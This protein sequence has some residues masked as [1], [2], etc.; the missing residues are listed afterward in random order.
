[1]NLTITKTGANRQAK[2]EYTC[3]KTTDEAV[4]LIHDPAYKSRILAGGT[5]LFVAMRGEPVD[6]GRLVDISQIPELKQIQKDEDIVRIGAAVTFA[7]ILESD[8]LRQETPFLLEAARTIGSPQ[9]RNLA[10]MGGNVANAAACADSLPVL[11]C[12]EASASL[13]GGRTRRDV[14]IEQLILGPNRTQIQPDELLI[15][16]SF[17]IL[18][19]GTRTAFV[20]LG[21]RN[22]LATTRLSLAA[23]GYANEDR[24]IE[25]LR[26]A[27]GSVTP[28]PCRLKKM[29]EE[30][31][32][33]VVTV[34]FLEDCSQQ[35]AKS[36]TEITGKRW[37]TEYKEK[38]MASMA[39][40]VLTELFF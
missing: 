37:S 15:Q 22:A 33:Q 40:H 4:H 2:Y 23:T 25:M 28:R 31:L 3:P 14:P 17:R 27:P 10:S 34:E 18:P 11:V 5:D 8:I 38:A 6:F 1:M 7:E 32:G 24:R 19:Q 35:I 29:E 21:R 26:I 20:K 12:L 9:I 30:Y 36:I 13:Q 16:L 39:R